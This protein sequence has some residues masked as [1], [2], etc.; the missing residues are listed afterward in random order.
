MNR[1]ISW[2]DAYFIKSAVLPSHYPEM[3]GERREPLSE[4]AVAG[5][6]NV[7]K[8]SLLGHLFSKKGLVHISSS[9]GKTQ[10]VNFFSIDD[11]FICVDLPGYGFA[12]VSKQV[13]GK[14]DTLVEDYVKNRPQLK[15]WLVLIDVRRGPSEQDNQLIEWIESMRI[16][17]I[18]VLTKGDKIPK[19]KRKHHAHTILQNFQKQPASHVLYSVKDQNARDTLRREIEN[20]LF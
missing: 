10:M 19:T 4:I 5:R 3:L 18:L 15:L 8:S 20:E 12:K 6:S 1:K 13:R 16:P 7:G 9:P 11:A 14:W 2:Q 17:W